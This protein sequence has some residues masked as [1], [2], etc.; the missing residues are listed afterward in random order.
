M[1]L[2]STS[3]PARRESPRFLGKGG[4]GHNSKQHSLGHRSRC[5]NLQGE[6]L[7]Y[8]GFSIVVVIRQIWGKVRALLAPISTEINAN[9]LSAKNARGVHF[10]C[11]FGRFP[12]KEIL[13]VL[14]AMI[15]KKIKGDR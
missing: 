7:A 4:G 2:S 11:V 9:D 6:T 8:L 12:L 3:P 13:L 5:S 14:C 15:P 10:C 1:S